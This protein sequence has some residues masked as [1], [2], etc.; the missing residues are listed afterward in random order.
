MGSKHFHLNLS[1]QLING[2]EK[3]TVTY[4][5]DSD[6]HKM[7]CLWCISSLKMHIKIIEKYINKKKGD[8]IMIIKQNYF[9]QK[10]KLINQK[11]IEN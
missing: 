8:K 1:T 2:E 7:Y 11:N 5:N 6:T 9:S 3:Y 4:Q 10:S